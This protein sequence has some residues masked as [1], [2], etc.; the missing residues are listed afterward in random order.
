[1]AGESLV[2]VLDGVNLYL[3]AVSNFDLVVCCP[4]AN[5]L[6]RGA[7]IRLPDVTKNIP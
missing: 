1:M 7:S 2:G 6:S 3:A 5:E 4:S